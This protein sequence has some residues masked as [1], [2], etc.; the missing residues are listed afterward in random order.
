MN[1]GS[2]E[3]NLYNNHR[4]NPKKIIIYIVKALLAPRELN[5]RS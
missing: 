3:V 1:E 5:S 4:Q 2:F